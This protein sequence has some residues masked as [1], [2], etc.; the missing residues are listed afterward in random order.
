[1][2]YGVKE[3]S[4]SFIVVDD[5]KGPEFDVMASPIFNPMGDKLAYIAVQGDK[6]FVMVD[7]IEKSSQLGYLESAPSIDFKIPSR[8]TR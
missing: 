1:M 6:V 7:S 4:K 8:K 3:G 2:A 5:K